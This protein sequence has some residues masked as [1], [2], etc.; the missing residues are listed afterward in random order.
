MPYVLTNGAAFIRYVKGNKAKGTMDARAAKIFD[1]IEDC[2]MAMLQHQGRTKG[3]YIYD[4]ET[5]SRVPT[6]TK[7]ESIPKLV[8]EYIYKQSNGKCALCGRNIEYKDFTIDHIVPLS[9][10]GENSI[11][12]FQCTCYACNQF[13]QN[14]LPEDFM[15]RISDIFLY[16]TEK[17]CKS[18]LTWKLFNKVLQMVRGVV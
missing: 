3:Y 13:K 6:P 14:I 2:R 10:G 16:Q 7:R 18:R 5:N 15:R 12:N 4:V 9:K 17:Q 11:D 1:S 8:R